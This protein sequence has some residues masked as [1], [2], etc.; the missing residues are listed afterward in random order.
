MSEWVVHLD[1][2]SRNDGTADLLE[3][4]AH[5]YW[6]HPTSHITCA[7]YV[8][9]R[10][11]KPFDPET[12]RPWRVLADQPMPAELADALN[13][14]DVT[15]K[16]WN[17]QFERQ[18]LMSH[19]RS[20]NVIALDAVSRIERY[21]CTAAR[22]RA[23]ALPGKLELAAR[24]L[25]IPQ[26]KNMDGHRLMLKWCK[27]LRDG[28]YADDPDEY[29]RLVAYC[30]QDVKTEGGMDI[31]LRDL[32][33]EEWQDYW[34]NERINDKGI[35]VDVGLAQAV[36]HYATAEAAAI[37]RALAKATCNAVQ[38]PRQF[39][40]IKDWVWPR[41]DDK[42]HQLMTGYEDGEKKISLDAYTREMILDD[43]DINRTIDP[44]VLEVVE[45]IDDAGRASVSKFE[46]LVSRSIDGRVPGSY[47]L[48]GGGQTGRYSAVG[49]QTHN[50]YRE[51]LERVEDVV[52]AIMQQAPVEEVV[53]AAGV[54][55]DGSPYTILDILARLM[56][57]SIVAEDGNR[58]VW[59]DYSAVEAR[60][61]PWLAD[62]VDAAPLL[63]QFERNEDVYLTDA[64][65]IFNEPITD[66]KDPRRQIGK[67]TRLSLGFMGGAGALIKMARNYEIK[68][69]RD[70]AE[71]YKRAFR[72]ANPWVERFG[73]KLH[74]AACNAVRNPGTVYE[75]GRVAYLQQGATLWCLLPGGRIICYPDA[76]V[77]M[78]DGQYGPQ[79][80]LSAIKGQWR[81]KGD[82]AWP[83][84]TLWMGILLENCTQGV[85]ASLLR[86]AIRLLDDAGWPICM[87]THDEIVLEV[88]ADEV[89]DAKM[90][91]RDAMLYPHD[92]LGGLP[93]HVDV[94]AGIVYK[95]AHKT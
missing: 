73:R 59:G 5:V 74:N 92:W 63:R 11:D 18:A 38:T 9:R 1:V 52:D 71:Y 35:P 6:H 80:E 17:A 60:G 93:L 10:A 66:K 65:D 53:K 64:S 2:E 62:D 24:C 23:V 19:A 50:L 78:V 61:L 20:S 91:L 45:L 83:R 87:H 57:S 77:T 86:S 75:A 31:V 13:D 44:K 76:R 55:K 39:Q 79:M 41:V 95:S 72:A 49:V 81:P 85:C 82:D 12:V 84:V 30:L 14:P 22:A 88:A 42:V 34:I 7:G 46:K 29:E 68:L 90:A 36:Q 54:D 4:G 40:K 32:T 67:V 51:T 48:N 47:I 89:D 15:I 28:S 37:R 27:P 26:Q 16:A 56:R 70:I 33:Q 21:Q 58:L 94:E 3:V 43:P 25:G 8:V 69:E